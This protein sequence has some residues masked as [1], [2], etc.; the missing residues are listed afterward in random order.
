MSA[1]L[2]DFLIARL[3]EEREAAVDAMLFAAFHPGY[4]W[5]ALTWYNAANRDHAA[6]HEPK[7]TIF[8]GDARLRIAR[9]YVASGES[10]HPGQE[11]TNADSPYDDACYLHMAAWATKHNSEFVMRLLASKYAEHPGYSRDWL[12]ALAAG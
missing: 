4:A 12:P 8:D 10:P 3:L 1:E 5:S 7:R 6:R 11:C 2:R 9:G